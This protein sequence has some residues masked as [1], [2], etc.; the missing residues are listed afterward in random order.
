[1]PASRKTKAVLN[2]IVALPG[3]I[4]NICF[5]SKY[6]PSNTVK[7]KNKLII[8]AKPSILL[9][10]DSDSSGFK[11]SFVTDFFMNYGHRSG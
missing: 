7:L 8:I 9:I 3:I 4:L 1:M 2:F 5:S 6:Q 10:I 11:L